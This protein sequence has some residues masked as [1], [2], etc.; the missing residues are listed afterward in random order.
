MR[1][2]KIH[3]LI[4]FL[5]IAMILSGCQGDV[6]SDYLHEDAL[7]LVDEM[8]A[9]DFTSAVENHR[10][11]ITMSILTGENTLKQIWSSLIQNYGDYIQSYH[12]KGQSEGT[13]YA[14]Y[15][16]IAFQRKCID[17]K[18]SYNHLGKITGIHFSTNAD[19]PKDYGA[20]S[21]VPKGIIEENYIFGLD[22]LELPATLSY[23]IDIDAPYPVVIL[24]HGSGP[25]DR[26][27]N[28]LA[29]AP[30]RDIAHGLA[31]EG[32]AVFRY[33]KRTF[34]HGQQFTS[35]DTPYEE[36]IE[37]A[38]LAYEFVRDRAEIDASRIYILGHSLGGLLMPEIAA[39]TNA[40]GYIMMAAPVTKLYDL[41]LYQYEY[42]Y[43]LDGNLSIQE[44]MALTSTTNE[45][46]KIRELTEFSD[47]SIQILGA[48]VPY[49][50]YFKEYDMLSSA[51]NIQSP[52][53]I[54]QGESDYQV[55]LE[56]FNMIRSSLGDMDNVDFISYPGLSHLFTLAGDPPSP[57]DYS[58]PYHVDDAVIV[59]IA[60][61]CIE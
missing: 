42:I 35:D 49:W 48:H 13:G 61:F 2:A 55:P 40:D 28:I 37:D 20:T 53:L 58:Q 22:G 30:F 38:V 21:D 36:T 47:Q 10:Y 43:N 9:G 44:K 60:D 17:L 50:L 32:I 18:F 4:F 56:E 31:D 3:L 16:Q 14:A 15:V 19:S 8:A 51:R 33:D 54:M 5:L 6:K 46:E 11:S 1:K 52:L 7:Q 45:V 24:V 29:Q 25:N 34:V 59:D 12:V 39:R 57:D 27:E 41:M 23:P 26:D